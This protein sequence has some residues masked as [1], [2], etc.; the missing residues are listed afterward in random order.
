[1][2]MSG[3]PPAEPGAQLAQLSL[4]LSQQHAG[5]AMFGLADAIVRIAQG[6]PDPRGAIELIHELLD[7]GVPAAA[8]PS[9]TESETPT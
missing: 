7:V 5:N 3:M 8:P 9:P 2:A 1:M 4:V 6:C